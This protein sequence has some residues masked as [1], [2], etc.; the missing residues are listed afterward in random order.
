MSYTKYHDPWSESDLRSAEA[1]NHIEGQWDEG[2][3]LVSAHNHD[4]DYY[5]KTTGDTTFITTSFYSQFDAD[6]LDGYHLADLQGTMLPIGAI[7]IWSG[8]DSTV[9][10]GWYVCDG[11]AHGGYTTPDLRERF[12]IGAG[13][14]YN[15]D[16]SGGPGSYNGTINPA[17]TIAVGDHTLTTAELPAHVHEYDDRFNNTV[18]GTPAGGPLHAYVLASRST[19]ILAQATGDG[20]HNHTTGS[21]ITF[22][23]IDPR[24]AYHALYYIMKCE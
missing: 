22:A 12:I 8:S 21:S 7:M 23:G 10:D 14:A 18:M 1:M 20:A 6:S 15:P 13:G 16:D 11:T 3:E 19:S 9:P 5:T 17:G 2:Y 4:S 24:P